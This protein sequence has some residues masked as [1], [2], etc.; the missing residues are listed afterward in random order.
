MADLS[1]AFIALPGGYGTL[2]EFCE[3]LTWAQLGLHGKPCGLLN[4]AGYYD[5]LTALLD[6]ATA[7]RFVRPEHRALV[8]EA[9]EPEALLA[10]L[11]AYRAPVLEKWI[12]R[13]ER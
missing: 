9:A 12:E 8:L 7:E 5:H 10:L 4:V 3:V 2:E 13:E 1:D 6:H 11:E